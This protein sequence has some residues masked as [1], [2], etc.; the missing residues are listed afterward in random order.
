MGFRQG[1]PADQDA[2]LGE[3]SIWQRPV[4]VWWGQSLHYLKKSGEE[5]PRSRLATGKLG[6]PLEFWAWE[7]RLKLVGS[8]RCGRREGRH[9]LSLGY[10]ALMFRMNHE[11]DFTNHNK[12]L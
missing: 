2:E 9:C 4:G 11:G 12:Y 8:G 10:M 1:S 3:G 5:G 7:N 6:G